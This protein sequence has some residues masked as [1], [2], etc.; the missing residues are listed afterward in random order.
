[1]KLGPD[2][3]VPI[4]RVRNIAYSSIV[5][6]WVYII[7]AAIAVLKQLITYLYNGVGMDNQLIII[8]YPIKFIDMING[9]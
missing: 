1:M 6:V 4:W 9:F 7:M 8:I 2:A 5:G 3:T